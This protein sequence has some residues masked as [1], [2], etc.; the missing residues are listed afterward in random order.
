MEQNQF[1]KY[2]SNA[3]LTE[4]GAL[5][6]ASTFSAIA[7]QFGKAGN[8]RARPISLVFDDQEA[9]WNENP[10]YALRFPFYLRA[11]TR[12]T[13]L[14][15][16]NMA[17][18]GQGQRDEAFKR[19]LW[20]A[21]FHSETFEKNIYLLP[22]I[23]SWKDLW[24]LMYYDEA[25][26]T[27]CI[28]RTRIYGIIADGLG[29]EGCSELVKK[30]MP[31]IKSGGKCKTEWTKFMNKFAKEFASL[32]KMSY[33]E[34]N[35]VKSNGTAHDFQKLICSQQYDKLNFGK[36]PGRALTLLSNSKFLENHDLTDK[37]IEWVLNS[38]SAKFT[39]YVYELAAACRKSNKKHVHMLSDKQFDE[40]IAKAKD[41][42]EGGIQGNV[43]CALDTSGSMRD[44]I[45][46]TNVTALDMCLSLGIFFSTL[47]TG[48]FHKNVIMFDDV[49]KVKQL[50]GTFSEM[51]D[52][53]V[54]AT[55]AW[56]STNFQ[57]VVN[58]IVRI[59]RARP[60]I[61]LEDYP[62]TLLVVSD[63]QFNPSETYNWYD[64][65][66][67]NAEQTKTNMQKAIEKL[68]AVFPDDFV[69]EFKFIWWDCTSR[70]SDYPATI[71][72]TGNYFYSGFDG[73]IITQLLG[74][75]MKEKKER[76]SME[77]V[78]EMA[79]NQEIF[80]LLVL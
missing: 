49:S 16:K 37:F 30:F 29:T 77:E 59:R 24:Q 76:P 46:G 52:Q 43:W 51:V 28:D 58:E 40:L 32:L 42:A 25:L 39:G 50:K 67:Y 11:I 10:E 4:N 71:E 17:Q 63:M 41:N 18:K 57:S 2:A 38:D 44:Q 5:S 34:Y 70:K 47:N 73:S 27:N 48:A 79:L 80:K 14:G 26:K 9:L 21:K 65:D 75:E 12:K 6:N 54:H 31:R 8:Y 3:T 64:G 60:E 78:I 33:K 55:T 36:I 35:H 68:K 56:G 15:E 45:N 53:L 1:I 19:L 62:Q 61:P 72:D 22:F 69:D 23:G 74:G 7:D 20:L 13:K 66:S